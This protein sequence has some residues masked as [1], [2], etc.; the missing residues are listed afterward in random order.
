M[1]EDLGYLEQQSRL[2]GI[3][4][5][6]LQNLLRRAV[7]DE[8]LKPFESAAISELAKRLR[9]E[10]TGLIDPD[11]D[12][13]D[14]YSSASTALQNAL[15]S[16]VQHADAATAALQAEERDDEATLVLTLGQ[17]T[18]F[19][20]HLVRLDSLSLPL[21]GVDTDALS[22]ALSLLVVN[23]RGNADK[24]L[25]ATQELQ[26]KCNEAAAT[27]LFNWARAV[28]AEIRAIIER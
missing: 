8:N 15:G 11:G 17:I 7:D 18:A 20:G 9:K 5:A 19:Q 13:R 3:D 12:K 28:E 1:R 23:G 6:G 22:N 10:V 26:L 14:I 2:A 21:N 27:G 16:V 4:T 24:L 25:R